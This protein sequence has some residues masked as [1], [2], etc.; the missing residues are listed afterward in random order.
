MKESLE[1]LLK[2]T[3]G[4][5]G[6]FCIQIYIKSLF[7]FFNEIL[8]FVLLQ[9]PSLSTQLVCAL[10]RNFG[11]THFCDYEVLL[12]FMNF[13]TDGETVFKASSSCELTGVT[14]RICKKNG[15]L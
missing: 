3:V 14:T 11:F 2:M 4:C 8:D 10:F 13:L 9:F 1:D 15:Q 5:I 12:M 6:Y 7:F